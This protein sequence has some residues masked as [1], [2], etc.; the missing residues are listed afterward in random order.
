MGTSKSAGG[1]YNWCRHE[2]GPP[3]RRHSPRIRQRRRCKRIAEPNPRRSWEAVSPSRLDQQP[4]VLRGTESLLTLCWRGESRAN[5]SLKWVFRGTGKLGSDSKT[6][7]GWCRK[8]K[9]TIPARIGRNFG[10]CHSAGFPGDIFLRLKTLF[11]YAIS[12]LA[13]GEFPVYKRA[14]SIA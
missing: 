3:R 14:A 11:F 12:E 9:G 13:L 5:Q 4:A 2:T 6:F 10:F 7:M 1:T 8:R